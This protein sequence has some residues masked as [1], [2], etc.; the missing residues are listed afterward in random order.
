MAVCQVCGNDYDKTFEG[1]AAL[2]ALVADTPLGRVS[3]EEWAGADR[4]CEELARELARTRRV[5]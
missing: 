5:D 3:P 4:D 1:A 2:Y